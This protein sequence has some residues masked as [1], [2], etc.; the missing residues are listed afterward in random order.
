MEENHE[1]GDIIGDPEARYLNRLAD[2]YGTARHLQAGYPRACPSL[3]AYILLTSGSTHG[4]CDDKAPEYHRLTGDNL[5]H[6][7]SAAGRE[8]LRLP[9]QGCAR[10]ARSMASAFRL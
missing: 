10:D 6:Q 7:V 4:V 9:P 8:L 1:Y 2:R 3:A 5:F